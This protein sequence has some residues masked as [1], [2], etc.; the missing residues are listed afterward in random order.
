MNEAAV[1]QASFFTYMTITDRIIHE[2]LS[3]KRLVQLAG[4]RR[5]FHAYLLIGSSIATLSRF[6]RAYA[7]WL[8][9][10][11]EGDTACG[12]CKSCLLSQSGTHP[13]LHTIRP[14]GNEISIDSIRG[15][16]SDV[17]YRTTGNQHR[18][19]II[20][21][22]SSLGEAAANAFLKTLEE[23]PSRTVFLLLTTRPDAIINTISSRCIS[24]RIQLP[25]PEVIIED[26]L[27]STNT[28]AALTYLGL[29]LTNSSLELIDGLEHEAHHEVDE[30]LEALIESYLA[31]TPT[32]LLLSTSEPFSSS[33]SYPVTLFRWLTTW[34]A[35]I[36]SPYLDETPVVM[37]LTIQKVN[38]TISSALKQHFKEAERVFKETYGKKS[39]APSLEADARRRRA[40]RITTQH[41]LLLLDCLQVAVRL[42]LAARANKGALPYG[43]EQVV[44][45]LSKIS[46]YSYES[47]SRIGFIVGECR[48]R[49]FANVTD[50]LLL[51][52][53]FVQLHETFGSATYGPP[54]GSPERGVC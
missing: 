29:L 54:L 28:P 53:F 34:L 46:S 7:A 25:S 51:L 45:A 19:F 44:P 11:S 13:A 8:H 36:E 5:P 1:G 42:A 17:D 16:I 32:E 40:R 23:P 38:S 47:L 30:G 41:T 4:D 9:C 52:D 50:K 2:S 3:F 35:S 48:K 37:A 15:I 10:T 43:L 6:A 26:F 20:E 24:T 39:K 21:K 22:A 12:T 14:E 49:L 33:L 31:A 18:V 27:A